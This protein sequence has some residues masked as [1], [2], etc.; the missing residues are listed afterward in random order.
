[1]SMMD[2]PNISYK[3]KS[4]I[5]QIHE[6]IYETI[7][8]KAQE[9]LRK[10][11]SIK[12]R[13]MINEPYNQ[14]TPYTD[15]VYRLNGYSVRHPE[16]E[17]YPKFHTFQTAG[18][19]HRTFEEAKARID[20]I[21][22]NAEVNNN[23]L[24]WH[25]FFIAEVPFGVSCWDV[26][27][28]QKRWAFSGKG[29]LISH[30]SISTLDDI[31]GNG[32]IYWGREESDCRF[33]VGDVVEIFSTRGVELGMISAM[34]INF[35]YCK[36]RLPETQPDE[37][38]LFHLDYSDDNYG[39]VIFDSDYPEHVEVIDCF[40]AETLPLDESVVEKLRERFE[41]IRNSQ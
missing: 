24:K 14:Y 17:S 29:E 38:M 33:K 27:D 25:A 23:Y 41:K 35:E 7:S 32:Q 13:Y 15:V 22:A 5:P 21:V 37:P 34:P 4:D 6:W 39:A 8:Q 2:I 31:N 19:I 11:K 28:G 9:K 1:M 36:K 20:E 40:P 26:Y 16:D 3:L 10:E 30:K 18:S 12:S